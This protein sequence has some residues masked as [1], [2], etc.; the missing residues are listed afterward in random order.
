M[1][2]DDKA[3]NPR[4]ASNRGRPCLAETEKLEAKILK[5][6]QDEF[7]A[8]GYGGASLNNIVKRASISKT[9]LYSRYASKAELFTAIIEQQIDRLAP[10]TI[11]T[12]RSNALSLN[13]GLIAYGEQMLKHSLKPEVMG[14]NRLIQSESLRFPELGDAAKTKNTRGIKRVAEFI[15]NCA[16]TEG[17]PCSNPLAVAEVFIYS[18]RGW[19]HN[20]LVSNQKVTAKQRQKWVEHVVSTLTLSRQDW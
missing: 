2:L 17:V 12:S 5:L 13:S 4:K 3:A 19:Y 14:I 18:L 20:I 8:K 11:L 15:A 1:P 10:E 7:L 6:A 16:E 9:T